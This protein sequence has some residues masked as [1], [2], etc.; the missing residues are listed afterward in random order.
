MK[1]TFLLLFLVCNQVIA[2]TDST[3]IYLDQ[4]TVT[5]NISKSE[6]IQTARNV[7]VISAKQI[8]QSPVKTIDGI[9]QYAL[10]VD[11]RSRSPFGVQSDVSIRGGN[12]EQTLVLIDG[13]K[14]NDP[15]TGHHSFNLPIPVNQ[16][17]KIEVLQGGASRVFGPAAFSGVINII[18]KKV[19]ETGI[20]INLGLGER[21]LNLIGGAANI[22]KKKLT[23]LVSAER[24]ASR[25]YAYNTA[26]ERIQ[27]FTK[28]SFD[29]NKS[30]VILQAGFMSNK[31][32]ASNFYHPKF[33]DQYEEVESA[34]L[35]GKW[36]YDIT[37]S[38]K[39]TTTT[40]LRQHRDLYDFNRF[41]FTNINAVN[42]HKTNVLDIEWRGNWIN[43]FGKTS[44]GLEYR[45][46]EVL[47]NRLGEEVSEPIEVPGVFGVFYNKAKL[48]ENSS[49]YF[50]HRKGFGNLNVSFGT[51][52]NINSQFGNQWF[53][54]L[55]LSYQLP[56]STALYGSIN[57]SYRF[58]TFTEM[59]L[60]TATVRG[61]PA[62][63]PESAWSYEAG[64]K[65]Q[66]RIS[67][68]TASVFIRNSTT[69]IDKVLRNDQSVPA[70]ENISNLKVY[71]VELTAGFNLN[72]I[73]GVGDYISSIG[74][75]YAFSDA[76]QQAI[77]FQSFYS[78][79]YLKHKFVLNSAFTFG[80][81]LNAS[82]NYVYKDRVGGYQLDANSPMIAYEPI[83]LVDSRISWKNANYL[84]YFDV[85]NL[86]NYSYFEFGFVEQ[87]KRWL[88]IGTNINL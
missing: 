64:L 54:G 43:K 23:S 19:E 57:R 82:L 61:N 85:N 69:A 22:K 59:Y 40:S 62:V 71:G 7:T 51:M 36:I 14:M 44:F 70:I 52:Y 87:P 21:N 56:N 16:I 83:H 38:F 77:D 48:R 33:L 20:N 45:K 55:D 41:R 10:G 24:I 68:F 39:S 79:N 35:I 65:K 63:N 74:F 75:N 11:V 66:N 80:E 12:F 17:E 18:T 29:L 28:N 31:F 26:F 72:Q 13:V 42:H 4:V 67:N 27:A 15:Q 53:P 32:G 84:I 34:F 46:E 47:S 37:P 78:L 8:E 81:H 58:P 9:L 88:S 76:N 49:A 60:N 30:E 1:Y 2:Q 6:L 3:N 73:D 5:A 25:G 50:E 86:L